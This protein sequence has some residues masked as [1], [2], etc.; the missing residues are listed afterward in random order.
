LYL[1]EKLRFYKSHLFI[2][3][4]FNLFF[5]FFLLLV[6]PIRE[7]TTALAFFHFG[8]ALHCAVAIVHVKMD[9]RHFSN[10]QLEELEMEAEKFVVVAA[11]VTEDESRN[12]F[13]V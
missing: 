4:P 7:Q 2:T 11:V 6:W 3:F 9:V 5:I 8:V 12:V 10:L 1:P 13:L